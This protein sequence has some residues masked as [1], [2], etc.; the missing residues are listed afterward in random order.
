MTHIRRRRGTAA[1]WALANPVLMLAEY[2]VEIDTALGK[3][4]D[5]STLWNDLDYLP[6][7]PP[8]RGIVSVDKTGTAG[9]V[10][11]YTITYDATPFTSTFT[12]TNSAQGPTGAT[13]AAGS[14]GSNGLTPSLR[15]LSV[16]SRSVGTGTKTFA[17][18]PAM[19]VA[20][21]VG[22]TVKAQGALA[23]NYMVGNV[24]S[25]TTTNVT[26]EVTEVGGSGTLASW[27][28]V[29]GAY[30]GADGVGTGDVVGPAGATNNNLA[31]F[32]TATGKLLKDG[33]IAVSA[34]ATDAEVT[35]ALAAYATL[36]SPVFTGNPTAPTP[37]AGDS[38]TSLATTAFV[39]TS[40]APLAS[41]VLTGNPTAPSA[42]AS[43]D[44][45]S[46]ATTAHVKDAIQG[47]SVIALGSITGAVSLSS[48]LTGATAVNAIVTAT[49]TGNTTFTA[50]TMPT[51]AAG[52]Q[53]A[54]KITQDGTGSR[55]LT[56]TNIKKPGGA[57]GLVLS[58]AAAAVDWLIFWYDGT[59]WCASLSGKAFAV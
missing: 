11:T 48:S 21:P 22:A 28:L 52:T 19:N 35:A 51:V 53:F 4:G 44:D 7:G 24:S 40:F 42:A 30:K 18:S 9:L 33:G 29:I 41:P 55:T 23:A 10:D 34:L 49:L 15:G 17:I 5:G 47:G 54:M 37:T 57:S 3:M 8:G 1:E 32:D 38:D 16:S 13:G 56:L 2:G 45:T 39:A 58:T 43:D 14:D 26:I 20:F 12:V 25:A 6:G 31:V 46:I 59:D 50:A 36:A 27:T